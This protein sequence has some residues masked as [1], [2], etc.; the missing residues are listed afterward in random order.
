MRRNVMIG[1]VSIALQSAL[2]GLAGTVYVDGGASGANNGSSWGNAYTSVAAALAAI[3]I[4]N[5]LWVAQGTYNE[6]A[7]I[8]MKSGVNMYGGFTSGM[9]ALGAR[10]WNAYPTFLTGAGLRQVI[11]GHAAIL[12]GFII[13]NGAGV[14]NGA[15]LSISAGTPTVQNCTFANN[16]ATT[17]GGGVYLNGEALDAVFSNCTFR[18]NTSV[19]AGAVSSAGGADPTFFNCTFIR[20]NAT[21]SGGCIGSSDNTLQ[22]YYDCTFT[23]NSATGQGG[24]MSLVNVAA[25]HTF[26]NC[27]FRANTAANTSGGGVFYFQGASISG[28]AVDCKFLGNATLAGPGGVVSVRTSG[29]TVYRRCVFAGN[30]SFLAGGAINQRGDT[31][32][33]ED[34]IFSGNRSSGGTGGGAFGVNAAAA[35]THSIRRTLFAGNESSLAGGA[36]YHNHL[37]GSPVPVIENCV[38]VGNVAAGGSGG[39]LYSAAGDY[40]LVHSTAGGNRASA[41]GGAVYGAAAVTYVTNSIFWGNSAGT[42]GNDILEASANRVSLNYSDVQGGW[43]GGLGGNNLNGDPLFASSLSG[44]WETA[45]AYD[46]VNAQTTLTDSDAAWSVNQHAGKTVN[47]DTTQYLQFVIA[48]NSATTLYL[49]GNA[50]NNRAGA[51][52]ADVGD[53]YQILSYGITASS[54]CKN[55][56][57]NIG[58]TSDVRNVARPQSG[59]YDMGAYEFQLASYTYT[60]NTT[61]AALQ[62][63]ADA[64]AAT[65][66]DVHSWEDGSVHTINAPSPQAGLTGTQYVFAA[67]SDAGAQSHGV[68]ATADTALMASFTTQVL[69]TVT[70]SPN[71][72]AGSVSPVDGTW[73]ALNAGFTATATANPGWVF[74]GWS[75]DVSGASPTIPVTMDSAK[76]AIAQFASS[77]TTVKLYTTPFDRSFEVDGVA[78]TSNDFSWVSGNIHTAVVVSATQTVGNTR[79]VFERWEDGSTSTQRVITVGA[80][81]TNIVAQFKTQHTLT[82]SVWPNA[83]FGHVT[84]PS[85]TWFDAGSTAN[86]TAVADTAAPFQ[87]WSGDAAGTLP[88]PSVLMDGPK[89]VTASF[90]YNA[91][92]GVIYVDDTATGAN[93]GTDWPNAYTSLASALAVAS[94]GND[95]WVAQGLYTD[96]LSFAMKANVDLFGGFGGWE[97]DTASRNWDSY[98]VLLDG[99]GTRT[100]VT[101]QTA[102]IDGFVITNGAAANGGGMYNNGTAPTVRNCIFANNTATSQGGAVYNNAEAADAVFSNCTFRFNTAVNGGAIGND[103]ADPIVQDCAFFRNTVSGSGGCI[104]NNNSTIT[105]TIHGSSFTSNSAVTAG[106][107]L[108]QSGGVTLDISNCVFRLNSSPLGGVFRIPA[109]ATGLVVDS[110]FIGNTSTGTGGALSMRTS[111][112][113]VYRGCVFAGNSATGAGG[114]VGG[115]RQD[116]QTYEDCVF[117]G[118]RSGTTGGAFGG[119]G[120]NLSSHQ[121]RRS[122]LAGNEAGTSGGAVYSDHSA[123]SL[124]LPVIE[125]CVLAGNVSGNGG[126]FYGTGGGQA[127]LHFSTFGGNRAT[128][129]G[130]A[131]TIATTGVMALT[132]CIFWGDSAGTSFGEIH[133]PTPSRADVNYSDVQGGWTGALGGNNQNSDPLFSGGPAGNWE[134]VAA[135]DP[136]AGQ[137]ALTDSGASWTVDEHAGKTVNPDTSQYLQFVIASNSATTLYVWGNARNNRTGG[138]VAD[139]ADNYQI[140]SYVIAAGSPCK[141]TGVNLGVTRDIRNVLRPQGAGYDRGAYEYQLPSYTYTLDTTPAGLQ[142]EADA[143]AATAPDVHSWESGGLHTINAP[144]PQAGL[145]GTQY[146]FAAWSDAGAQSHDVTA[147]ADTTLMASFTTQVQWTVTVSPSALAGS[148]TP[149]SGTWYDLGSIF[150]ATATANS[151]WAFTGWS[152]DVAGGSTNI[153]VTMNAS[154][155]AIA[156]FA[157]SGTIVSLYT[158]PA[159]RAFAVDGV[160]YTSNDFSWVEGHVH[161]AVVVNATQTVGNTRYVFQRWEDGSTSTQ[162]VITVGNVAT[163]LV[164]EF[165]TQY[166][167]SWSIWPSAGFGHVVPASGTFFD[168]GSTSQAYAV[169]DTGAPFQFWSGDGSGTATNVSVVMS[170]PKSITA[171]FYHN[172]V[173]GVIYVDDTAT[174]GNTG[175]DWP[176]AYTNLASALAA[177]SSGMDIW[178]AAGIYTNSASFAMKANVDLYGG[179]GGWEGA[180][181]SRDWGAYPALLDGRGSRTVV[182]AETAVIDGFVITNGA[183]ANGGGLY[184]NGTAPTVRNCTFANNTASALGGAVYSTGEAADPV[185]T[186][187]TFAF[188]T[189]ATA[190]G[191]FYNDYYGDPTFWN[192]TFLRNSSIN[193]GCLQYRDDSALAFYGCTFTS[194][195]ASGHAGVLVLGSVSGS[196]HHF[197]NCVFRANTAADAFGGGV[198][199]FAGAGI[200]GVVEDCQFMSNANTAGPGGAVSMRNG[201]GSTS[202]RRC[203]FVDNTSTSGGGAIHN[204]GD[205]QTY[206]DCIFSANRVSAGSGGAFG[207]LAT[208]T[209]THQ[210]RRCI[211]AGNE[212]SAAGGALYHFHSAGTPSPALENCVLAGNVSGSSGGGVQIDSAAVQT[213]EVR[214]CTFSGNRAT[215]SGGAYVTGA[216]LAPVTN[217]IFWGNSAGSSVNEIYEQTA[218]KATV[219]YSDVQGGWAGLGGNNVSGDPLFAGGPSGTWEATGAYD[220]L[221]A[222][223]ALTDTG[224]NWAVNEHARKTVNPDTAQYLQFVIASNSVNT[225]YVWGNARTSRAGAAVAGVGDTYQIHDFDIGEGSAAIDAGIGIGVTNDVA[226]GI[227]PR[228]LGYDMGAYE[229]PLPSRTVFSFQ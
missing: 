197:S 214:H 29:T 44:T 130:G 66:P 176:N 216:V 186:N 170:A 56:G 104:V 116:S 183:A 150:A 110:K 190:A 19:S 80:F 17:A 210:I 9:A 203:V 142:V 62:V 178:V 169:P 187:C 125:N 16:T 155:H 202:Y 87:Y 161:T 92:A 52:V 46:A 114:A 113:V 205:A 102:V 47:P 182:T 126:G 139:V 91:V 38:L 175:A 153:S 3:G 228:S 68:T 24:V 32:T 204:R 123:A 111:P 156:Q 194:N 148:V 40:R 41:S 71:P 43:S 158:T 6:G 112:T 70:V 79:H 20:N 147:T 122:V 14:A 201:G 188:N 51:A 206:E 193:G 166:A 196:T 72:T 98:P 174:G 73:H 67:W 173:A 189:S 15:G 131:A 77:G 115:D 18:F 212:S 21:G 45:V 42:S 12:D 81:E 127:V 60:L 76:S 33:Y 151:G 154:K 1:V 217:S 163:N 138:A 221:H 34:C 107:V 63:E 78:F 227:R 49:W 185:F 132:N 211:F 164:A 200:A 8:A 26:S 64:V 89:A 101:G 121:L 119:A 218:N 129:S 144:S 58:V 168:A 165:K 105:L 145:T 88:S 198:F 2:S 65:A 157:S 172:A 48:S 229:A 22:Q 39:A 124:P 136:S 167:L 74:T 213:L 135:Y 215:T 141:D 209:S 103:A 152:G 225:L 140:N 162:R 184:I 219:H 108:S 5:D 61:P 37:A 7:T 86:P 55:T 57:V 36:I 191:A 226:G 199:Y 177:A 96:G 117:S 128:T 94:S 13:T 97:G 100:V 118:N 99:Q 120:G 95:I 220:A 171:N 109:A 82:W 208:W 134:G 35:S 85:G 146:V 133:E 180:A 84:P 50:R 10:D 69:W 159:G 106:G 31:Q 179:F 11:T 222:Q 143:V 181:T 224:A 90:Y 192:C 54:P 83:G 23:S 28:L 137:T 160:A 207:A 27:T 53:T 223:T 4:G 93:N 195:S 75:G 30:S 25:S 59:G 149:L